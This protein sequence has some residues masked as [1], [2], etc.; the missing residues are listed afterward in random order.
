M[1]ERF[2]VRVASEM[3]GIN[4]GGHVDLE[5]LLTGFNRAYKQ[6]GQRVLHGSSRCQNEGAD[7]AY[8]LTRQSSLPKTPDNLMMKVDDVLNYA[9][10][11]SQ[12]HRIL[13]WWPSTRRSAVPM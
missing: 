5:I 9:N 3:L 13:T 1:V 2:N 12:P 10:D 6:R 8:T 4:V 7:R 11:V